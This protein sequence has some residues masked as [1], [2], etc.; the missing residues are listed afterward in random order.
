MPKPIKNLLKPVL[1]EQSERTKSARIVAVKLFLV[2]QQL[3]FVPYLERLTQQQLLVASGWDKPRCT[4]C[5]LQGRFCNWSS[6]VL[7]NMPKNVF[8]IIFS[9]SLLLKFQV[10]E[11]SYSNAHW[12][13]LGAKGGKNKCLCLM[14]VL[15]FFFLTFS[16]WYQLSSHFMSGQTSSD[17]NGGCVSGFPKTNE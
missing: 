16:S 13:T 6:I 15:F 14:F 4:C 12:C 10:E 9:L 2:L 5:F 11:G 3:P 8:F 17:F 7:S 1:T